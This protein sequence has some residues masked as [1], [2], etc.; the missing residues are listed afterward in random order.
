MN[1]NDENVTKENHKKIKKQM[2]SI[3]KGITNS[4]AWWKKQQY[5]VET[6]LRNDKI[7]QIWCTISE[8]DNFD[9]TLHRLLDINS[10]LDFQNRVKKISSFPHLFLALSPVSSKLSEVDV[11]QHM[12][13]GYSL[14]RKAMDSISISM[15]LRM[16]IRD[17]CLFHFM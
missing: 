15:A 14:S 2:Y 17:M 16:S 6:I 12:S 3:G 7:Q 13:S 10:N 8:P 1:L 11:D 5:K 4:S 9:P